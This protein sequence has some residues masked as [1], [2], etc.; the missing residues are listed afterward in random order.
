MPARSGSSHALAVLLCTVTGAFLV[1]VLRPLLPEAMH[2]V[3]EASAWLVGT[4]G[5][6]IPTHSLTIVLVASALAFLW[7]V[8]FHFKQRRG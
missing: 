1:D 5:I 4:F 6:P 7:G 2:R 3:T 8:F